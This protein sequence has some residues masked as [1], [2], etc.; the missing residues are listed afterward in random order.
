MRDAVHGDLP[1]RGR[2]RAGPRGQPADP[3]R[4][5]RAVPRRAGPPAPG[6]RGRAGGPGGGRRTDAPRAR[7][8]GPCDGAPLL[9]PRRPQPGPRLRPP[10]TGDPLLHRRDGRLRHRLR[11]RRASLRDPPRHGAGAACLP[12]GR[13]G[14]DGVGARDGVRRPGGHAGPPRVR[15]HG[16]RVVEARPARA[17]HP[18]A[19]AVPRRGAGGRRRRGGCGP[20]APSLVADLLPRRPARP[21]RADAGRLPGPGRPRSPGDD[22]ADAGDR[23][24]RARGLLANIALANAEA[25]SAIVVFQ[26]AHPGRPVIYSSATGSMDFRSGGT[27]A[28]RRRWGSCRPPS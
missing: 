9:R 1:R 21:R 28:G 13:H 17:P 19:G 6:G 11:V 15:R 14:G 16:P 23:H 10:L 18:P 4:D 7:R 5:G 27:W 2:P 22:H 12:G 8:G 20:G 26:L 24:D 25:L 3:R